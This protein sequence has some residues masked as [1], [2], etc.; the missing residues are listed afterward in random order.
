[1]ARPPHT[2]IRSTL[3][4]T[5][6]PP[7]RAERPPSIARASRA[8]P[9]VTTAILLSGAKLMARIGTK[10]PRVKLAAEARAAW[11]GRARR[12]SR[13]IAGQL[14]P[15]PGQIGL[16]RIRLRLHRHE[17]TGRHRCSPR[18]RGGQPRDQ[19]LGAQRP[20]SGDPHHQ[21]RH[22]DGAVIGTQHHGPQPAAAMAVVL[23]T[24]APAREA[25]ARSPIRPSR[26]RGRAPDTGAVI[27]GTGH[28]APGIGPQHGLGEDP[29]PGRDRK[30]QQDP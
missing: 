6:A 2:S 9:V 13:R 11:M 21:A 19:E 29:P 25:A 4:S 28:R 12:V 23:L 1:M 18:H 7:A 15:F 14:P 20:G 16:L 5:A 30:P 8:A 22:R 3:R 27:A 26:S 24:M 17:L 10:D